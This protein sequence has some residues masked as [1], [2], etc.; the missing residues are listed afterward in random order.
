MQEYK[1]IILLLIFHLKQQNI[2]L[3]MKLMAEH[4]ILMMM[5]RGVQQSL[6]IRY[7]RQ[8]QSFQIFRFQARQARH[9][10][11]GVMMRTVQIMLP[12]QTDF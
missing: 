9:F 10:W 3:S 1:Q 11:D 5:N 12:V 6:I 8:E 7:M 2:T 4:F